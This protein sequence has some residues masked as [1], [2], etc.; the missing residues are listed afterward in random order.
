MCRHWILTRTRCSRVILR[1]MHGFPQYFNVLYL[2]IDVAG[3]PG[4]TTSSHNHVAVSFI[5]HCGS[6]YPWD[7][8][9]YIIL[10][11]AVTCLILNFGSTIARRE[12]IGRSQELVHN[13]AT[14]PSK[15]AVLLAC[16]GESDRSS[17]YA[18]YRTAHLIG[19]WISQR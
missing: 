11:F 6:L 2:F 4:S 18:S 10:M 3:K 17:F 16:E 12:S 8:P 19:S 7:T 9:L 14:Q 13:T 1:W 5:P 15:S